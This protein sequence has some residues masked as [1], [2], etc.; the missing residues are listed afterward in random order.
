MT[1]YQLGSDAYS[2]DTGLR[3]A[4]GIALVVL[5]TA[6]VASVVRVRTR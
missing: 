2:P 4:L 1:A 6:L 5:A 3:L